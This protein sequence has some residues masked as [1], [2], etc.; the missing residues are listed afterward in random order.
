MQKHLINCTGIN[1]NSCRFDTLLRD[2]TVLLQKNSRFVAQIPMN[3]KD[4]ELIKIQYIFSRQ[5]VKN[6]CDSRSGIFMRQVIPAISIYMMSSIQSRRCCPKKRAIGKKSPPQRQ[7]SVMRNRAS[8]GQSNK[9]SRFINKP[10][11]YFIIYFLNY[12][13]ITTL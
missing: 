11:D 8:I 6:R 3:L 9:S 5:F 13:N 10:R 12:Y 4:I 7:A 2:K 1:G